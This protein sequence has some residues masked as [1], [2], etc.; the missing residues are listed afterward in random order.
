MGNICGCFIFAII[1]KEE[2]QRIQ[3]LNNQLT[4]YNST[5]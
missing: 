2:A 1:S 4:E 5:N 3:E